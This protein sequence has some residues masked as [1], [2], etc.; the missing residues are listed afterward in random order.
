MER[1]LTRL[2]VRC[3]TFAASLPFL[4]PGRRLPA[5]A[6]G[7]CRQYGYGEIGESELDRKLGEIQSR[8]RS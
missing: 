1:E 7:L 5:E 4:R 8:A 6:R 3:G 2:R